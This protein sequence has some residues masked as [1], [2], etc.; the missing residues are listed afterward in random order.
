MNR[1]FTSVSE[2]NP[3]FSESGV[4]QNPISESLFSYTPYAP[5]RGLSMRSPPYL[6][7]TRS[8]GA[9]VRGANFAAA[10]AESVTADGAAR[11]RRDAANGARVG[12]VRLLRGHRAPPVAREVLG[13]VRAGLERQKRRVHAC[14]AR[15]STA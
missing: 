6:L 5:L 11:R 13:V 7:G 15:A 14:A 4:E 10:S 1:F 3:E 12:L 8:P 2:Q 9:A